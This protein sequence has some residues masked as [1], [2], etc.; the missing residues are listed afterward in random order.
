MFRWPVRSLHGYSA[1][2]PEQLEVNIAFVGGRDVFVVV[3]QLGSGKSLCLICCWAKNRYSI[4]VVVIVPNNPLLSLMHDMTPTQLGTTLTQNLLLACNATQLST[5]LSIDTIC[6][7][8]PNL[9]CCK[10]EYM[11]SAHTV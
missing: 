8:P 2:K 11:L 10:Y 4:V 5:Q 1:L 7:V 6:W 3:S 9:Y